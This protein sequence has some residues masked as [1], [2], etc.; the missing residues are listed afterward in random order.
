MTD[1]TDALALRLLLVAVPAVITVATVV[2]ALPL[3]RGTVDRNGMYGFRTPDALGSEA[4]WRD[5]N[6]YCGRLLLRLIWVMVPILVVS[7]L[8]LPGQ[9]LTALVISGAAVIILPL[10]AVMA[11]VHYSARTANGT[12]HD[13]DGT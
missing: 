6:R 12:T 10:A 13:Q 11:T 7:V 8:P 1:P 9:P 5:V 3:A 2:V 4:R